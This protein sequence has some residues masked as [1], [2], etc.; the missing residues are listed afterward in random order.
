[1]R[2]LP[3][4]EHFVTPAFLD[5]PGREFRQHMLKSGGARAV[6]IFEQLCDIG[7]AI[8]AGIALDYATR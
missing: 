7:A 5:G 3:L 6:K 8:F 2:L 4:E 1:M